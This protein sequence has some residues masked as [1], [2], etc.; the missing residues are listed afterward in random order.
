ML[1]TAEEEGGHNRKRRTVKMVIYSHTWE[2]LL[3][4]NQKYFKKLFISSAI[5]ILKSRFLVSLVLPHLFL[6]FC[7]Y[8][9]VI[10][11]KFALRWTIKFYSIQLYINIAIV[12]HL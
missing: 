11:H 2:V 4:G 10:K 7:F 6:M 1:E 9:L 3:G 5:S 12:K 8:V